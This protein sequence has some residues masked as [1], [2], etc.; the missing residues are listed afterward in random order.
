MAYESIS[1]QP[2]YA[3]A[4][5]FLNPTQ[6]AHIPQ[7]PAFSSITRPTYPLVHTDT[8]SRTSH[9]SLPIRTLSQH[10]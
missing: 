10:M 9:P 5:L 6:A 1:E 8:T 2:A 3:V 4:L 7:T